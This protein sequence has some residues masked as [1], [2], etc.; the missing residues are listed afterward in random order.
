MIVSNSILALVFRILKIKT[1]ND[2][3]AN[4]HM[5]QSKALSAFNLPRL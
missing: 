4:L 2:T 5:D 3:A 1:I